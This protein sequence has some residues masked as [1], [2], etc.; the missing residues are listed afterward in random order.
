MLQII[1]IHGRLQIQYLLLNKVHPQKVFQEVIKKK[2]KEIK[3]L[4]TLKK[5]STKAAQ[6]SS[7]GIKIIVIAVSITEVGFLTKKD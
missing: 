1:F 2:I 5:C 3:F 7:S 4:C 6:E